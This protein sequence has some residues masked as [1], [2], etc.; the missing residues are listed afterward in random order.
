MK[1]FL[2]PKY[3]LNV[4]VIGLCVG[5]ILYFF[6]SENGLRDLLRSKTPLLWQWFVA[7]LISEAVF[8]LFE[9]SVIYVFIKDDYKNFR[10]IDAVK[11]ALMGL[12]WCAV[13]PSLTG[14]QPM[15]VYLL[16]S[17]KVEVGYATSRLTQKFMVYQVV[18]TLINI[19][20]VII[21]LPF[22]LSTPNV[23][24]VIMLLALGFITQI[25]VTVLFLIFSFSE[26][27]SHKIVMFVTKLLH[28]IRIIKNVD[29]KIEGIEKQLDE[30]HTSNREI[31]KKP[32]LLTKAT[33]LTFCQFVAMFM[34]SYFI[35]RALGFNAA[36]PVQI[37]SCQAYV[38]LM[39]G[40]IP[41]PGASGA[42][43]LGFTAFFSVF[44][45]HGTLK[46]AALIWRFINYYLVVFVTAPF[47]YLSKDKTDAAKAEEE[48]QIKA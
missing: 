24:L 11:T 23:K 4:A 47:A 26:K 3:I 1:K 7:A 20:S 8:M 30:F 2:K 16:H 15:Q 18:L 12:F 35:Y 19:A 27:L 6:F 29:E 42:A 5:I 22:I 31:Y 10:F 40:M 17:M 34:V 46:S 28:K 39:S 14:G 41:I 36:S 48:K 9:S 13:T 44:F 37:M 33:I 45:L 21:N 38:N 25:G 43:E 32:K